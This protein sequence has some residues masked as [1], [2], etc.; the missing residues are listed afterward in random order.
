MPEVVEVVP[1][2]KGLMHITRVLVSVEMEEM[3]LF[4]L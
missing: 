4:Q 1:E 3:E 2:V